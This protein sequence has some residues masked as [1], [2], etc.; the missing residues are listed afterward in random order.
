MD[1]SRQQVLGGVDALTRLPYLQ[2][3]LEIT[4][5]E[6]DARQTDNSAPFQC[7]CYATGAQN[8]P[9]VVD[10]TAAILPVDNGESEEEEEGDELA[11]NADEM[12]STSEWI[13]SESAKVRLACKF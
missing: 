10:S 1:D 13:R 5:Q 7:Q 3:S 6:L 8:L 4:R 12:P 9:N 11:H 2:A